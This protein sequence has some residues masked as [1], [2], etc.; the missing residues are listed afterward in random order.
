MFEPT[1]TVVTPSIGFS[2]G[3]AGIGAAATLG[4]VLLLGGLGAAFVSHRNRGDHT[5]EA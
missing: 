3:D 2:W 1:A 5:P 4:I